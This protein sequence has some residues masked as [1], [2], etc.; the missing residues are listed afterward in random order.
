M[1]TFLHE[2]L[3][4]YKNTILDR[5]RIFRGMALR[6]VVS[7]YNGQRSGRNSPDK[8]DLWNLMVSTRTKAISGALRYRYRI[9]DKSDY[10]Y[11]PSL[12]V[13]G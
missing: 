3:I 11:T 9:F 12:L 1:I 13:K 4:K 5:L 10:N 6:G 8:C 7:F 2:Q